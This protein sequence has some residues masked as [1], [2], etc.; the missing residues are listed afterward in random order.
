MC[1][2]KIDEL[3]TRIASSRQKVSFVFAVF[4]IHHNHY[5]SL[6]DLVDGFFNGIELLGHVVELSV[7]NLLQTG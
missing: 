6:L 2:H 7:W 5:A 4:V 1:G 3:R